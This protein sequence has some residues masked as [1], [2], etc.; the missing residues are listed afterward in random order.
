MGGKNRKTAKIYPSL[1]H[2]EE[3]GRAQEE[4]GYPEVH[5]YTIKDEDYCGDYQQG[6]KFML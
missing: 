6:I 3:S 4:R 5:T 1:R 2:M